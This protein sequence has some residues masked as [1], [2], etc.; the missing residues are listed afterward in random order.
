MS[1]AKPSRNAGTYQRNPRTHFKPGSKA[2]TAF[3]NKLAALEAGDL[4][5]AWR[6]TAPEGELTQKDLAVR[7]G[8]TQARVSAIESA[9]GAEGPSYA[10]LKKIA[11]ACGHA[12]PLAMMQVAQG[13][14]AAPVIEGSVADRQVV[15]VQLS[16][17]LTRG[18]TRR[19]RVVLYG[20]GTAKARKGQK[21]SDIIKDVTDIRSDP[22]EII[23]DPQTGI[24]HLQPRH[25]S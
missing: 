13:T 18:R 1:P 21:R 6:K 4:V 5:R 12:W 16:K 19:Q 11:L 8:V 15:E 22:T 25:D 9:R 3:D 7:L 10:T 14:H 2:E 23:F 24:G 20:L 17:P